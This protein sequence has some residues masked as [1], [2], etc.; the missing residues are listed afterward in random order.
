MLSSPWSCDVVRL[1]V[2]DINGIEG[3]PERPNFGHKFQ[4]AHRTTEV[5]LIVMAAATLGHGV[6][7]YPISD[8]MRLAGT[9]SYEPNDNGPVIVAKQDVLNVSRGP[10]NADNQWTYLSIQNQL[11]PNGGTF[12]TFKVK[13]DSIDVRLPFVSV[14]RSPLSQVCCD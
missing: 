4:T 10:S 14:D 1:L 7:D 8:G 3:G 6:V 5:S 13:Y 12:I 9:W 2:Q 11:Y